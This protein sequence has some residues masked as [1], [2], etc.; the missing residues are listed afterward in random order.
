MFAAM[1]V[2]HGFHQRGSQLAIRR[3][4]GADFVA[5]SFDGAGFVNVDM[6]GMRC[7]HSLIRLQQR[8]D[9]QHI[10][11]GA[12]YK[13][14]DVGMGG[15][16]DMANGVAGFF[17]ERIQTIT[18]GLSQVRIKQCLKNLWMRAFAVIVSETVHE[19]YLLSNI[20]KI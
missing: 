16:A 1:T 4:S 17:T 15:V 12:A 2:Y 7:D 18:D 13:K 19:H 5:G 10:G 6:A 14:M 20:M 3:I 11:L 9:N 8:L